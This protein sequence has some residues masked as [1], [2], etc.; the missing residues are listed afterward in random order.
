MKKIEQ[1]QARQLRQSGTSIGDI[2]ESLRVSKS[3][4]SRWVRNTEMQDCASTR[5]Y[6]RA[7]RGR[8]IANHN[9]RK[10][11][12]ERTA[13]F[14]KEGF[15]RAATDQMFQIICSLYWGEGRK[16]LYVGTF[17][18]C[19]SDSALLRIVWEWI[20]GEGFAD[21]VKFTLHYHEAN[22]VSAQEIEDWWMAELSGL[23]RSQFLKSYINPASKAISRKGVG[24]LPYGTARLAVFS[25]RL[26]CHILGGIEFL[27]SLP[28]SA[29]G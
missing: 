11:A 7:N 14:I 24:K 21:R 19:N 9:K 4:V 28:R 5:V 13:R 8:L 17:E 20:K 2:A 6:M 10:A 12:E 22:G 16:A 1:D 3:S 18:I 27:K 15:D 25:K 26:L 23:K 29:S